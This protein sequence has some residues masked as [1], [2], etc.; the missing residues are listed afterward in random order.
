MFPCSL[1]LVPALLLQ[2]P[3]V[4]A[5]AV[6]NPPPP[7]ASEAAPAMVDLGHG[8]HVLLGV[9][10]AATF[11]EIKRLRITQVIDFRGDA[12][13]GGTDENAALTAVG[14]SY[15]RYALSRTPPPGDFA[16]VRELLGGFPYG[17][18]VLLHCANGNRAAAAACA[19]LVL[20][21]GMHLED[22][23]K[24]CR[25]AGMRNPDTEAALRRYLGTAAKKS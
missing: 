17:A 6:P 25:D 14:A 9:P 11:A 12:E 18:R 10:T 15:M 16:F 24:V 5:P 23:I 22:A 3:Q 2:D 4:P 21:K 1:L 19:W 7:A 8:L 13:L 20:D